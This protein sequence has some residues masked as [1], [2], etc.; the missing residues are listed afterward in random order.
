MSHILCHGGSV[1]DEA[2]CLHVVEPFVQG[3]LSNIYPTYTRCSSHAF[4]S[5][6]FVMDPASALGVTGVALQLVEQINK[7]VEFWK[8]V[9]KAPEELTVLFN[10]LQLLSSVLAQSQ[11]IEK[12]I[13]SSQ[14]TDEIVLSCHS[15]VSFLLKK[16]EPA[17]QQFASK[18][19]S[20]R[21]WKRTWASFKIVLQEKE[22]KSIKDT[23]SDTKNTLS[24]HI[25]QLNTTL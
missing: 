23:I 21:K 18:S 16:I 7:L 24:L 14:R 22:I 2:V 4:F 1:A 5:S 3:T 25:T 9:Q 11:A 6:P 8:A 17:I 20:K 12:L 15:K 19:N 13:P 10:D